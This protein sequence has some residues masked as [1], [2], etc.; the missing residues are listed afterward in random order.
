[1]AL[2]IVITDLIV[3]NAIVIV[4]IVDSIRIRQY[5]IPIL[6]V[7]SIAS[8]RIGVIIVV[9]VLIDIRTKEWS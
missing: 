7:D 3:I 9:L 8:Y 5:S 2:I 6:E 1:M 4:A